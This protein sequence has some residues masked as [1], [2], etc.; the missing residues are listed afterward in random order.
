MSVRLKQWQAPS[1]LRQGIVASLWAAGTK[2]KGC[3]VNPRFL[4]P[5]A[6]HLAPA[7]PHSSVEAMW[8]ASA[9]GPLPAAAPPQE[10]GQ[11]LE[12][13]RAAAPVGQ[14]HSAGLLARCSPPVPPFQSPLSSAAPCKP[15]QV[16]WR[17]GRVSHALGT[18]HGTEAA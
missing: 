8:G 2:Q 6:W 18:S 5:P 10:A 4:V 1:A 17:T 15:G 14:V 13:S 11:G 3:T 7:M 9:M 16:F 12:H